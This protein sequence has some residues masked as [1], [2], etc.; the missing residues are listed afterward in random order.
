MAQIVLKNATIMTASGFRRAEMLIDGPYIAKIESTVSSS[1]ADC[2]EIDCHGMLVLPGLIDAHVHFRQPGMEQKA[3]IATES[4]AAALGGVTSYMDMPNTS[5]S[6]TT[7]E[8]LQQ[9]KALAQ[10]DSLVNYGFYLGG[11]EDNLEEVKKVDP[12]EIAGI[13]IYMGS[14]T[15]NL[16][17]DDD[18]ALMKMFAAAPTLVAVHCEDNGIV[19]ANTKRAREMYGEHIPFSMHPIIRSRDC[20]LKSTQL[21]I[22]VAEATKAR[23]HIMHVSTKDEVDLLTAYAPKNADR[24]RL[25]EIHSRQISAE[26]CIPH[27]YFNDSDYERLKGFL[28]CNPAVKYEF[29]RCALVQ[30]LRRGI[31]TTIGTDHAPHERS[32]KESNDYLKVASGLPSVQFSLPVI[33]D[34]FKRGEIS[35]E[36]GIKA[37]TCNVAARFGIEKRGSLVEGNF[38]DVVVVDPRE[39]YSVHEDDIISLCKW[40]PFVGSSFT[41]RIAHTIASGVHVVCNGK[42]CADS[43]QAH[44]LR[45]NP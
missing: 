16:L 26:V 15:G 19:N 10:R 3:T 35:L 38:A 33:F 34:L 1:Q 6:T 29:D 28:K 13:K 14:T 45:F 42:L 12:H 31:L 18:H 8:L 7:V 40:S 24:T 5:P 41:C 25:E 11:S 23:L 17:L 36:E 43:G 21:A 9:K 2:R 27:L 22:A 32:L 4:R 30:G 39:R 44:A 20:C 37:A